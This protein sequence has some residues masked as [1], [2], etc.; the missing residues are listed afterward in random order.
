M[1]TTIYK[2]GELKQ[3]L[4]RVDIENTNHQVKLV[5]YPFN[6]QIQECTVSDKKVPNEY[7]EFSPWFCTQFM[8]SQGSPWQY[9]KY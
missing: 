1:I 4:L 8:V 7:I 3:N 5:N 6:M 2:N 9:C